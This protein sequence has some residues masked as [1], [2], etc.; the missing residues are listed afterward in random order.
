MAKAAVQV[1]LDLQTVEQAL[2]EQDTCRQAAFGFGD[3]FKTASP[4]KSPRLTHCA[5]SHRLRAGFACAALSAAASCV[6]GIVAFSTWEP[7]II[8]QQR[9]RDQKESPFAVVLDAGSTGTRVHIYC[10]A[11][12]DVCAVGSEV[13]R[14]TRPGLNSCSEPTCLSSLLQP[15]LSEV[16]LRVP[17][18]FLS[19]T[20]LAVRATA[21]FRLLDP[22]QVDFL[23]DGIQD[24]VREH[25]LLNSTV[26][27]MGGDDE[28]CLQWIEAWPQAAAIASDHGAVNSLLGAFEKDGAPAA[29]FELGGASAQM[30]YAVQAFRLARVTQELQAAYIRERLGLASTTIYSPYYAYIVWLRPAGSAASIPIYQHSYLGYG[31]LAIR[32]KIFQE[33]TALQASN[34]NPCLPTSFDMEYTSMQQTFRGRGAADQARCAELFRRTAEVSI[35]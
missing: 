13:V 4:S 26:E 5:R 2:P 27:V 29:V 14:K 34:K 16:T 12:G 25:A 28:G 7:A 1:R 19:T 32:A 30:T 31:I 35:H 8:F 9:H 21:G 22:V 17:Q 6:S 24:L 11:G 10:F 15:L 3:F 20:P 23:L 18:Q 33:A